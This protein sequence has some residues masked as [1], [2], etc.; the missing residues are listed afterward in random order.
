MLD[1]LTLIYHTENATA[2]SEPKK[3]YAVLNLS[4]NGKVCGTIEKELGK[5]GETTRYLQLQSGAKIQVTGDNE[6]E[7]GAPTGPAELSDTPEQISKA[8]QL[9][10]EVLAE[11]DAGSSGTGFGG[12]K[13]NAPRP[14]ADTFQMKFPN[15]NKVGFVIGK[16]GETI[17][18]MQA[19][20]GAC[21]QVIPL[22]LPAGDTSTERTV[23]IDG[24]HEQIE[25]AKQLGTKM[26]DHAGSSR[27]FW[28]QLWRV[29]ECN[30]L[31]LMVVMPKIPYSIAALTL[32]SGESLLPKRMT[33]TSAHTS[34]T[35]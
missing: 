22:H 30:D 35:K 5:A 4:E 33:N 25:I 31:L 9:I 19:K 18:S 3:G 24:T 10:K 13:Y 15:N 32:R 1:C 21:I 14:G 27:C 12:Q 29:L 17:K 8:E 16:G 11:A 6:A 28:R 20:S 7:S 23:H 34:L 2:K 26:Q